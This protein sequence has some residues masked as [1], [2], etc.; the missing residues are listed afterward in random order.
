MTLS[1]ALAKKGQLPQA[2][3][4]AAQANFI[5]GNFKQAQIFAKRAQ[6]KLP[7]GSPEWNKAEEIISFKAP[8]AN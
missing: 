6:S 7:Q 8:V 4:A 5:E 2:E 1:T 3:Y